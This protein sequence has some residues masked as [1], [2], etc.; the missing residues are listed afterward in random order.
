MRGTMDVYTTTEY[1]PDDSDGIFLAGPTVRDQE[2]INGWRLEAIDLFSKIDFE[3]DLYVPEFCRGQ[4][5][6]WTYERQVMWE[7]KAL[8]KARIILFWIPRSNELPARTTNI[9]FG[10]YINSNKIVVGC[11]DSAIHMEY[12][13][14]RCKFNGIPVHNELQTAVMMAK[15]M[16]ESRRMLW[17]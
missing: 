9:E 6:Y 11:P 17:G 16:F 5:L 8:Q 2:T 7:L 3:Y 12:I 1:I 14:S 4:P 13:R 10:E 15:A